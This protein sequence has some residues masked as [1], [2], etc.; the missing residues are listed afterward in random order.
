[1]FKPRLISFTRVKGENELSGGYA[2][3][4]AKS[5]PWVA[6]FSGD[7]LLRV[8]KRWLPEAIGYRLL[9]QDSNYPTYTYA[10]PWIIWKLL[11][12]FPGLVG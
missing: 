2:V 4:F 11:K 1:M 7:Y 12:L 6:R 5:R 3:R 9:C 10:R 8:E